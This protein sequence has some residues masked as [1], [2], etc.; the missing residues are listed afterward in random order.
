MW[1]WVECESFKSAKGNVKIIDD[2]DAAAC[3][4]ALIQPNSAVKYEIELT[5]DF[6]GWLNLRCKPGNDTGGALIIKAG[7]IEAIHLLEA[8]SG[9][10]WISLPVQDAQGKMIIKIS[11]HDAAC[12]ADGFFLSSALMELPQNAEEIDKMIGQIEATE[13]RCDWVDSDVE[14]THTLIPVPC[15][16]F[17]TDVAKKAASELWPVLEELAKKPCPYIINA[18]DT[19]KATDYNSDYSWH[20]LDKEK[21]WEVPEAGKI[22]LINPNSD[23]FFSLDFAFYGDKTAERFP[24]RPVLHL[25]NML[26]YEVDLGRNMRCEVLFYCFNSDTVTQVVYLANDGDDP[27]KVLIGDMNEKESLSNPPEQRYTLPGQMFGAGVT[28]TAG[29]LAWNSV[30]AGRAFSTCYYEWVRGRSQGRRLL[31]TEVHNW[32]NDLSEAED[33]LLPAEDTYAWTFCLVQPGEQFTFTHVRSMH[34]F[35]LQGSW[36]PELMPQLYKRETE[37]E[38]IEIGYKACVEALSDDIPEAIKSS[39]EPYR[40]MPRIAMPIKS[41]EADFYACLELPRAST[42]SPLGVMERP[43]YNF[44]R[45]H[46]HEP[47]GWWNYG[48]HAHE[49]LCTLFTNITNPHL[50]ADYLRGHIKCQAEDGRYPY[51][52]SHIPNPRPEADESTAPL[53]VWEAWTS[54]LWSGDREFLKEAYESGKRNM[55]WWLAARDRCGEGLCHWLDTSLESVRDDDALATWQ[56]TGGGQYQEALDLNCYLLVQEKSLAAMAHELGLPDEADKYARMAEHRAKIMNA[57][58]WHEEDRCYYGINEVEPGFARVKDISTFFPLWARLAPQGRFEA[59]VDLVTDP[60]T[61]GLPYGPPTLAANEPGFAPQ[62][63]WQGANWVEMSMFVITGLKYYRCYQLAA[64]LAYQNTK[65]VFDELEKYGHFREYFNSIEGNGTDLVDYIWT[66]MPAH[67]VVNVFLGIEPKVR[68]LE[69]LPALPE[70]WQSLELN[71]LRVRGRRLSVSVKLD[72]IDKTQ[73]FI[74][75]EPAN[76]AENRGVLVPWDNLKD[77]TCIEIVQPLSIPE[78]HQAPEEAPRD[79]SDVPPHIYPD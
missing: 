55:D 11:S 6:N 64:D 26:V 10:Q 24:F 13:A 52:V 29:G 35:T 37:Q 57:Y 18:Y 59:L 30:P 3:R 39:I 51:G 72:D 77:G 31:V 4:Y 2:W 43:F 44:C 62:K 17:P 58:M 25:A 9:W 54:Y 63:H 38:A 53:I 61:F 75:G 79:W 15:T 22:G 36:N 42:F 78:K 14:Q 71:D 1:M 41:W 45:V 32:S 50:S 66:A 74:N 60:E 21:R 67:F 16:A 20:A 56:A 65:M 49:D 70:R 7:N 76:I 23:F 34:R 46:A 8:N 19:G 73:A 5:D 69:V 47:Y 48:M 40:T 33:D 12:C 68:H 27:Q 28:T